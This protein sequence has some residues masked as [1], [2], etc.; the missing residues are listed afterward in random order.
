LLHQVG[1]FIYRNS[2]LYIKPWKCDYAKLP[3]HPSLTSS[4]NGLDTLFMRKP[5]MWHSENC[6]IVGY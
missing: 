3:V 1:V 5:L 4:P 6:C 2:V